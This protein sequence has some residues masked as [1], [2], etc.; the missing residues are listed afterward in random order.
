MTPSDNSP[1]VGAGPA[2]DCLGELAER[3]L[4]VDR[5]AEMG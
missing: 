2:N 4:T 1:S 3:S 5:S